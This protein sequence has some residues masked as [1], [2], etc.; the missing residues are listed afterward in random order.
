VRQ[1]GFWPEPGNAAD[2]PAP[3]EREEKFSS[4]LC[5]L[6][7]FSSGKSKASCWFGAA[8]HQQDIISGSSKLQG[9]GNFLPEPCNLQFSNS[10]KNTFYSVS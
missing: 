2:S 6:E 1:R 10:H 4:L 5:R 9:S 8:R 3:V 7:N